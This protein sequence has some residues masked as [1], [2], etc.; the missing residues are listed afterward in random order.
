M[1]N[2]NLESIFLD[3]EYLYDKLR[4]RI[5]FQKVG[6]LRLNFEAKLRLIFHVR[7][8]Y[9]TRYTCSSC[10]NYQICHEMGIALARHRRNYLHFYKSKVLQH[11]SFNHKS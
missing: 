5:K 10:G 2:Y 9:D 7:W 6:G 11:C 1:Q 8:M 4:L 3:S